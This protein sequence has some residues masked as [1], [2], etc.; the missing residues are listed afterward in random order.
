MPTVA[1]LIAEARLEDASFTDRRHTDH[2]LRVRLATYQ[3]ELVRKVAEVAPEQLA[4]PYDI[5]LPL[6]TFEDG[7]E[8]REPDDSGPL[9]YS[10]IL[11][12]GEG[13]TVTGECFE[14]ENIPHMSRFAPTRTAP[15]WIQRGRVFLRGKPRDW[16][17]V[18]R[19]RLFYVPE[20]RGALESDDE[21][22]F[23]E[24]AHAAY[25]A[26][27]AYRM[28]MRAKPAELMRSLPAFQAEWQA[29]ESAFLATLATSQEESWR[30]RQVW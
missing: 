19:I 26:H 27:L 23:H 4:T 21:P 17:E 12:E 14:I 6:A 18:T 8:L 7:H 1:S 25:R 3:T 9:R 22:A 20:P 28:A 11:N 5:A 24:Q 2:V 15:V 10:K 13:E 29:E 16:E 30:V